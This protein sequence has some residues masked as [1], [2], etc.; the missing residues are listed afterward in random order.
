M[1]RLAKRVVSNCAAQQ[2][3]TSDVLRLRRVWRWTRQL[4]LVVLV[5]S[6]ATI[7]LQASTEVTKL[8]SMPAF[9][10]VKADYK[11][12][13]DGQYVVYRADQDTDDVIELY[14]I[15]LTG[16]VPTKLSGPMVDS[17][18]VSSFKISP[19]SSQVVYIADQNKDGKD[20]LFSVPI[21]GPASAG[22]TINH[23]PF[24]G[25][26]DVYDFTISPDSQWVVYRAHWIDSSNLPDFSAEKI[27]ELYRVP[28]AGGTVVKLV[29]F[30]SFLKYSDV[31]DYAIS[32]DGERI[33]YLANQETIYAGTFRVR[34]LYSKPL[35]G[36]TGNCGAGPVDQC[37]LTTT[38]KLNKTLAEGGDVMNFQVAHN[39]SRVVYAADQEAD[40]VYELFSVPLT[41]P[42]TAGVK[43]SGALATGGIVWPGYNISPD[44]IRV[45]YRAE[46][47]NDNVVEVYSVAIAGASGSDVKLNLPLVSGGAVWGSSIVLD[48]SRALYAGDI[49]T[50]SVVELFSVPITGPA[51]ASIKL[52]SALVAG[53]NVL[54]SMSRPDGSHVVYIADQDADN[55]QE[56]YCVPAAGPASSGTKISAPQISGGDVGN[57]LFSPHSNK[58]VY[59]ADQDID[60]IHELYVTECG[61]S[62]GPT[63]THSPTP[64]KLFLPLILQTWQRPAPA[65]TA[66]NSP[67]P[68]ITPPPTVTPTP[69]ATHTPTPTPEATLTPTIT[70]TPTVTP[71]PTATPGGIHG[72]VTYNH[73]PAVG[74]ELLLRFYNGSSWST[75]STTSTD[76]NGHYDFTGVAGLTG[77]QKIYVRFNNGSNPNYVSAWFAPTITSYTGGSSVSGGDFDIANVLLLSPNPGSTLPLPVTFNWQTRGM[78]TDTY[79]WFMFEPGTSTGW[80]TNDLGA[81]GSFTLNSLPSGA[82]YDKDYGWAVRVYNGP[83]SYGTSYYAHKITFSS[84]IA[85]MPDENLLP[86]PITGLSDSF[87]PHPRF[88]EQ[89]DR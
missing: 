68:T 20:E 32:P 52:N 84:G 70:P 48:S 86:I 50:D 15:P 4:L 42:A 65:P 19:D 41:G 88:E 76:A 64:S 63:P 36:P 43:I 2:E 71:T 57:A 35:F 51:S 73:L 62:P 6:F 77:D 74:I 53:G 49:E 10:D 44:S 7:S 34:E 26:D 85:H 60:D 46:Q 18:D 59:L 83:D 72:Q 55:V 79:R 5:I 1:F 45:V 14:S 56:L 12:S 40:K 89:P 13:P 28:I 78:P 8:V 67:T 25:F 81:S 22:A 58:V 69:S 9:G 37:L 66:T 27:I 30:G 80:V 82:V 23:T 39:G 3:G 11:V 24:F 17:G 87:E 29:N 21:T 47:D 31:Y 61:E 38:T 75:A 54:M 16:G 33:V